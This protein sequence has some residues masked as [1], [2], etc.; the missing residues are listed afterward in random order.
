MAL[1]LKAKSLRL[2]VLLILLATISL[3]LLQAVEALIAWC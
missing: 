2:I 3:K 1:E